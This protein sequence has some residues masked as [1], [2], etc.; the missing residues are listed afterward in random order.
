VL[1]RNALLHG[2][3]ELGERLQSERLGKIVVDRDRPGAS[4]AFTVTAKVASFSGHGRRPIVVGEL[5]VEGRLSP[6]LR[7]T[8]WSSKP[9]MNW[10]EPSS[11]GTSSPVPPSNGVPSIV[12]WNEMVT[13]SPF[14]AAFGLGDERAVLLG[15]CLQRLIDFGVG[16]IGGQP[17]SLMVLKSASAIGGTI[18]ISTV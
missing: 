10:P 3:L 17:V 13:R 11:S 15:N 8:R 9:G 4:T 7:P 1:A 18:S 12:P 14:S 2:V 16:H 6:A 5:D